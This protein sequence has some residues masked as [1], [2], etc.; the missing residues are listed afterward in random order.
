M[1][2]QDEI[3][4]LIK[5]IKNLESKIAKLERESRMGLEDQLSFGVIVSLVVFFLALP[6]DQ[7]TSFFQNSVTLSLDTSSRIAESVRNTGLLFLISASASRYY[8]AVSGQRS[9]KKYRLYS[10]QCLIMAWNFF[11]LLFGIN[12]TSDASLVLGSMSLPVVSIALVIVYYLMIL[13]EKKALN[14]YAS[15][16]F[17]Y[18]KDV[19]ANVSKAFLLLAACYYF[20][21][22]GE[23]IAITSGMNFSAE[24]FISVWILSTLLITL[25]LTIAQ[26]I[27]SQKTKKEK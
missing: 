6:L 16:E 7:V 17:I 21:F 15:K 4:E 5:R 14:F 20:A 12:V 19:K 23:V 24:R 27:R 10:L 26:R 2:E 8:A 3:K 13:F 11:I 18:K 9:S 1:S 22:V 25:L